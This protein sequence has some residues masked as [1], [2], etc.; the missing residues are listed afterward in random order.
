MH[1][2]IAALSQ[3]IPNTARLADKAMDELFRGVQ[4]FLYT[5]RISSGNATEVEQ[6]LAAN[7]L[8]QRAAKVRCGIGPRARLSF[9]AVTRWRW[10]KLR[11][12]GFN[13]V[14]CR[15]WR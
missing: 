1:H 11:V 15:R 10:G 12:R 9:D 2:G 8:P 4:C 3:L 7:P 6:G 5:L 14:A 13:R